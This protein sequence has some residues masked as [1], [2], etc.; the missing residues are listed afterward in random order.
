MTYIHSNQESQRYP[1]LYKYVLHEEA[2]I[3]EFIKS[4]TGDTY[5]LDRRY[6]VFIN[7]SRRTGVPGSN[8]RDIDTFY[9]Y[10]CLVHYLYDRARKSIKQIKSYKTTE[11]CLSYSIT[12]NLHMVHWIFGFK[13]PEINAIGRVSKI[14][15]QEVAVNIKLY[16]S[17]KMA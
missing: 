9:L 2:Y 16:Q 8:S 15:M 12:S 13:A 6:G 1:R 10:P 11:C 7:D 14:K 4:I 3:T 17:N 5:L